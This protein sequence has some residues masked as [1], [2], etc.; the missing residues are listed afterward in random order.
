MAYVRFNPVSFLFFF[1]LILFAVSCLVIFFPVI[2]IV[3]IV[4]AVF[5]RDRL[6]RTN[7]RFRDSAFAQRYFHTRP[8]GTNAGSDP[9][10]VDVGFTV[11]KDEEQPE[12]S[13]GQ[14]R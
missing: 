5:A 2:L 12:G 14:P 3:L 9:D 6:V 7:R 8:G 10:V 11:L 13:G 1:F 4:Y